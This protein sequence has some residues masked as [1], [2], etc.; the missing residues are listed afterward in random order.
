MKVFF[1]ARYTRF[2]RHDG[3]SRYGVELLSELLKIRDDVTV[4]ISDQRQLTQLPPNIHSV[5]LNKPTALVEPFIA[6]QLNKLGADV[7]FSPLQTM[8][9]FGKKYKLILTIHDLI[10]YTYRTP[11]HQFNPLLRLAWRMYHLSYVPERW[12]LDKADAVAVVSET[13][14]A[15]VLKH[16]LTS[17]PVAVI[18]NAAPPI[19]DPKNHPRPTKTLVYMGSFVPYKNVDTLVRAMS[20]LPEY[21]LQLL[22]RVD[23]GE[24][25]RLKELCDNPKQLEFL[26]GASDEEYQQALARATAS[27]SASRFEGFGIPL[28]EAQQAGTPVICSDISIHHE[29]AGDAALFFDPDSP[30]ALAERVHEL[31]APG[32]REALI[33]KGTANARRYSWARSARLLSDLIDTLQTHSL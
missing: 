4:I 33:A 32:T 12:L 10:Y 9:S 11:P 8:G 24:E 20:L 15:D 13:T 2:P 5:T 19:S 27:V 28:L 18:P 25:R 3:V 6:G 1:D 31:E 17:K 26:N 30:E 22:S 16:A 7:V 14:K 23:E 29:V 21:T